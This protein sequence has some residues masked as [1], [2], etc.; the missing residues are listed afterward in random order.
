MAANLRRAGVPLTV[1]NRSPARCEVLRAMGAA[2]ASSPK[3]LFACCEAIILMLADDAATDWVLGRG[4]PAFAERVAGRLV[5]NMG[6]HSPDYSRTLASDV[7]A[8]GGIFVEAPVSGSRGPAEAGKLVAMLAGKPAAIER[9]RPL[10]QP[11][12]VK[13]VDVG[14]VP[15]AMA[16]KMA[17]NLYLVASVTA[18]AEATHLAAALDL[19]LSCF[20]RIVTEGPLGSAVVRTKLDKMVRRDFAPQAS[21]RDV[22]KNAEL[23]ARTASR[24]EADVPLLADSLRCFAAASAEGG[25]ALDMA[26]VVIAYERITENGTS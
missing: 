6:T 4:S 19:D 17:V 1:Y 8:A 23:I 18:L 15:S 20:Y 21:I 26:A 25:N 7:S 11:M 12:C 22:L 10:L 3:A 14:D 5:I 16:M 13:L 9:V 24:L 2:V